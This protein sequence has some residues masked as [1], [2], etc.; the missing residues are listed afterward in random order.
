ME[1]ALRLS[2]PK[3]FNSY[4]G[5]QFTS[6][7]FTEISESRGTQISMDGRSRVFGN[8]FIERLWRTLKYEELYIHSYETVKEA[9]ESLGRYFRFYNTKRL[10]ESLGYRTPGE[11]YFGWSNSIKKQAGE[12]HLK[13]SQ[14][15][16]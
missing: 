6:R 8:I 14:F 5:S 12:I 13:Q 2:K 4:Q 9:R 10:H 16:S 7:E 1:M 15:L 11:I 3:V